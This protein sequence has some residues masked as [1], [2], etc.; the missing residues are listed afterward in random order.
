MS[1]ETDT[2]DPVVVVGEVVNEAF[3]HH[4]SLYRSLTTFTVIDPEIY[5]EICR[6]FREIFENINPEILYIMTDSLVNEYDF[7]DYIENHNIPISVNE[8]QTTVTSVNGMTGAVSLTAE[9]VK[10]IPDYSK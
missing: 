10:A 2:E 6:K 9:D 3:S 4:H 1:I 8:Q 7:K 5:D